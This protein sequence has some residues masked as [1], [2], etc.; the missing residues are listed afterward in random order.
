MRNMEMET[1]SEKIHIYHCTN[2]A[3]HKQQVNVKSQWNIKRPFDDK[4]QPRRASPLGHG[5][6]AVG[7]GRIHAVRDI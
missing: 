2:S 1:N 4:T 3:S 7:M 5:E 6:D